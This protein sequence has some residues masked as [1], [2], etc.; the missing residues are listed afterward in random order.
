MNPGPFGMAQTG[1]P[2]GDV[3]SVRDWLGISGN[4]GKPDCEHPSRRVAGFE[5][6]RCE[7]SGRRLWGLFRETFPKPE[8]F[9]Q[10]H[11]VTNYCP[12][13]FLEQSGRNR[14]PDKLAAKE[15]EALYKLCDE[16]LAR[17][18]KFF[19]ASWV[20]GI[21]DFAAK[22]ASAALEGSG[23]QIGRILHP[24]PA[25]PAA[26]KDWAGQAAKQLRSLGVWPA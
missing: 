9:F 13:A 20:I 12:L 3:A 7:V 25:C 22:R 19:R 15:K 4:V 24:S 16:H 1:V 26:N 8:A 21:G 23:V 11:F 17:S 2:F 6:P 5:C 18:V 14:T 10:E